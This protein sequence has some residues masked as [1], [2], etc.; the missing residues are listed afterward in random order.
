MVAVD[1]RGRR[2]FAWAVFTTRATHASP[3]HRYAPTRPVG[4]GG[5]LHGGRFIGLR[6]GDMRKGDSL[7]LNHRSR[8]PLRIIGANLRFGVRVVGGGRGRQSW[9]RV[10]LPGGVYE[11]GDACVAPT[12]IYR[13]H[14]AW[15]C[16]RRR[17]FRSSAGPSTV[18][19]ANLRHLR[20]GVRGVGVVAVDDRGRRWFTWRCLR[21]GRRVRRPYTDLSTPPRLECRRRR[22]FRSS[23]GPSTV[24]GANLRHLRFGVRGFGGGRG[25]R[26]GSKVVHLAVFTNR[27]TQASPPHGSIDATAPGMPTSAPVPFLCGPMMIGDHP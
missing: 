24:I 2:W 6:D 12:Q 19:G 20:F 17:P 27:A 7:V 10:G 5:A 11:P 15:G 21:T 22:P 9:S 3:L 4:R 13:R 14:R 25:R 16:R 26:S 1:N 8:S 18:I 23:A